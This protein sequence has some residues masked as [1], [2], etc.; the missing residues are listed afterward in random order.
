MKVLIL[1]NYDSFTYNL[2]H[3]VEGFDVEV[4]VCLNNEV[5]LATVG[6]YDK[7]ILSPGP[8]LPKNA[9]K[10]PQLL[11]DYWDKLPILGVCLGFQ[12]LVEFFGGT[13]YN[14]TAVKHGI[15]ETCTVN[16][17][18]KLFNETAPH[19]KIGL[20]HSW[21]AERTSFPACLL[22]TAT[23][24]KNII[25]GFEHK[26]KPLAGVQFHPESIL[27]QHGHQIVENFLFNFH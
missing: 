1:D 8:G 16:L 7:V 5:D 2:L 26:T 18:S 27:S 23:S 15:S 12:A 21:A 6:Q 3:Y 20:Y 4:D 24:E 11:E 10:M 13:L 22:E 25:M 9:G 19:F 14:Q 17:N